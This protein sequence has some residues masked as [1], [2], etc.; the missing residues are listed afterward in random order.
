MERKTTEA[1]CTFTTSLQRY[2]TWAW[3]LTGVAHLHHLAEVMFFQLPQHKS[4]CFLFFT[5][6]ILWK[7]ASMHILHLRSEELY[8][9]SLR[10]SVYINYLEFL[11]TE[12]LYMYTYFS[13]IIY[14]YPFELLT[15]C[16]ILWVIV[17]YYVIN[18]LVQILPALATENSFSWLWCPLTYTHW[19]F[20][21]FILF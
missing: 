21:L 5:S 12:D 8:S 13:S 7:E 2:I 1:K 10:E 18:F 3:I 15:I 14:L 19:L 6:C 16:L 9:T 17:Y 4:Y 20:P 11:Y